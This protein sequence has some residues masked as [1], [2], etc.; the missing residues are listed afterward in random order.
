MGVLDSLLQV[1]RG[2]AGRTV[3]TTPPVRPGVQ[4]RDEDL[5]EMASLRRRVDTLDAVRDFRRR[6]DSIEN[7]VTGLGTSQD[8]ATQGV[9]VWR[10]RWRDTEL[11]A[12]Y[13]FNPYAAML[14]DKPG[15]EAVRK[16]WRL[17]VGDA[18]A[19]EVAKEQERTEKRLRLPA[20]IAEGLRWGRL[21][22]GAIGVMVTDEDVDRSR[23]EGGRSSW[24][25]EPMD[26]DRVRKLHAIQLLACTSEAWPI[27]WE[28][29][30]RSTE[31]GEPKIW[32]IQPNVM[33]GGAS[34]N[35][36]G[37]LGIEG[38]AEV[39]RSRVLWFRGTVIPRLVRN[40]HQGVDD[41]V[42]ERAWDSI[43]GITSADQA[44]AVLVHELKIDV[45]KL[46]KL[47][48][49]ATSDEGEQALHTR[50]KQ[51]AQGKSL[52]NAI[53]I[54]DD[55]D[56]SQHHSP[57]TGFAELHG[58][59]ESA[60]SAASGMGKAMV[61]GEP[62]SGLSTDGES[63]RDNWFRVVA[64][65]QETYVRRLLE[66]AYAVILASEDGP[67]GGDVPEDWSLEFNPLDQP[68]TETRA[69]N[70]LTIAQAVNE[71]VKLGVVGIDQA[72]QLVVTLLTEL[73]MTLATEEEVDDTASAQVTA[74]NGAQVQSAVDIVTRVVTG[75][76]TRQMA[77]A[78]LQQFF[79]LTEEVADGILA[80]VE[81]INP[82]EPE[83]GTA[84]EQDDIET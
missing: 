70:L 79:S 28:T 49:V 19:E 40:R 55:E 75:E 56:Y 1:V 5:V 67:T 26:L 83:P 33:Y 42:I 2:D 10:S 53:V 43:Q 74:L 37:G 50:L 3:A 80:D 54:G 63:H 41:S 15:D 27:E 48:A 81:S 22:G 36:D 65:Y 25:R 76:I 6:G 52:L 16:G 11:E 24:L 29:D 17:I 38:T 59:A 69:K 44:M 51:I 4:L 23:V 66:K 7:A 32:Q 47:S 84:P 20:V 64:A 39:H 31:Y 82:P 77:S 58:K 62:P 78:M 35:L 73:D 12:L 60:Y 34:S 21:Y 71:L 72:N 68:T 30:F 45:I 46:A 57:V 18:D 9:P 14:V 8:K 61:Y 13:R